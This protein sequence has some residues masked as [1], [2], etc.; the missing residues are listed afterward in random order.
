MRTDLA[1]GATATIG[2]ARLYNGAP[3]IH[4]QSWWDDELLYPFLLRGKSLGEAWL[5][6]Q[7]HLGWIATF[8]G[9]PLYRLPAVAAKDES[10]PRFDPQRNIQVWLKDDKNEGKQVWLTVD[11]GSTPAN[12]ETAQLRAKTSEGDE[13]LCQTFE[14]RP[15]AKLGTKED[16]CGRT[17]QVETIDPYGNRFLADVVVDCGKTL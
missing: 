16:E 1:R 17:W 5:L 7:V 10:P 13:A 2:V 11:L 6:N 8:V 3:H 12:P 4:S 15:Y 14:A 9:D